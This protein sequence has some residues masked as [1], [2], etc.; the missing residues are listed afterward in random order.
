MKYISDISMTFRF[1]NGASRAARVDT[2]T[3]AYYCDFIIFQFTIVTRT[4]RVEK[5]EGWVPSPI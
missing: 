1:V 3:E 2:I 5:S 4:Y